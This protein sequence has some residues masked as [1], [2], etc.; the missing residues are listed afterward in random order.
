MP[1]RRKKVSTPN[2]IGMSVI[3]MVVMILI[4]VMLSQSAQ[5]KKKIS[6]YKASNQAL[7]EQI[8]V[9]RDRAED[10]KSLPDYI[11][12]DEYVEKTARE[13][14]GLVY[15]DEVIYQAKDGE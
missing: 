8:Q 7:E 1:D 5:M 3:A 11:A 6:S 12:S 15:Q 10:L 9:E 2:R 13:K 4:A 14:F